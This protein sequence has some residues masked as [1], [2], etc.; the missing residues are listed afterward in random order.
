M[1][2]KSRRA[3]ALSVNLTVAGPQ[4][5]SAFREGNAQRNLSNLMK[6]VDSRHPFF[7]LQIAVRSQPFLA[8]KHLLK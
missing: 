4:L 2:E 5:F 8:K 1:S 6:L 3:G 7:P